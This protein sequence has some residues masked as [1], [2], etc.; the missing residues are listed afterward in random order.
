MSKRQQTNNRT[1]KPQTTLLFPFVTRRGGFDTSIVV[2]N[3]SAEPFGTKPRSGTCSIHYFGGTESGGPAP[4]TRTAHVIGPGQQLLFS[5]FGGGSGLN[6]T[7]D[8]GGYVVIECFFP[9]A[10]GY[11][12]IGDLGL[13]RVAAGYEAKLLPQRRRTRA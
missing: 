9:D 8:F 4:P 12:M 7:P 11:A 2:T 3:A 6:A 1:P 13:Q 5:F 10:H